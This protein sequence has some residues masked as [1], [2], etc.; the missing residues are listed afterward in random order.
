M[1]TTLQKNINDA[2]QVRVKVRKQ[3]PPEW[4]LKPVT[5]VLQ[6]SNQLVT[7]PDPVLWVECGCLQRR[8]GRV[9]PTEENHICQSSTRSQIVFLLIVCNF[10]AFWCRIPRYAT[11]SPRLVSIHVD[12]DK[13]EILRKYCSYFY[14]QLLSM[15]LILLNVIFQHDP[16]WGSTRQPELTQAQ[17]LP[18]LNVLLFDLRP[19]TLPN[20]ISLDRML[21][22]YWTIHNA[23]AHVYI[24]Q[25]KATI[26]QLQ[27][28]QLAQATLP[29]W[30]LLGPF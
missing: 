23:Q 24:L 16:C 3:H 6:G 7:T 22:I 10:T 1:H 14:T 4:R 27:Q 13:V 18:H 11:M 19:A 8:M 5:S 17:D 9:M 26:A 30:G 12:K 2:E 21:W 29:A 28:A 15:H 25:E 20:Y